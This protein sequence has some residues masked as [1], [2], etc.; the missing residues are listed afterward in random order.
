MKFLRRRRFRH[1]LSQV[2]YCVCSGAISLAERFIASVH[3]PL[4]CR[5]QSSIL[6]QAI[7]VWTDKRYICSP[8]CMFHLHIQVLRV[9]NIFATLRDNNTRAGVLD[10]NGTRTSFSIRW[11]HNNLPVTARAW[12]AVDGEISRNLFMRNNRL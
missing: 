12:N 6:W 11:R 2:D 9:M 5:V 1:A 8:A 4:L 3:V 10:Y 7:T